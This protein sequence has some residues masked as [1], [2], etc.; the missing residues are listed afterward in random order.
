MAQL[1]EPVSVLAAET[2]RASG[3]LLEAQTALSRLIENEAVEPTGQDPTTI[4]LLVR[5][6]QAPNNRLRA[7]EL[8]R[9]LLMSPSHISRTIDRA[10]ASGLVERGADPDDRRA[11]QIV[12]TTAGSEML[13]RFA[14]RL[15]AIIDRVIGETLSQDEVDS[16]VVLLG[17]I[18]EAACEPCVEQE[19]S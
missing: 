14:P 7:I 19:G 16:L 3:A 10:E 11:T 12:L 5:L 6:D 1:P 8:S 18:Q 9:Q 4:D 17:R 2:L 13:E 15:Q